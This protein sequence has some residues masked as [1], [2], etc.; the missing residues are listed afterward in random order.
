MAQL[1]NHPFFLSCR[2]Y[3]QFLEQ[4]TGI[5][6]ETTDIKVLADGYCS[7]IDH[8]DDNNKNRYFSA[9]M[10]RFW[11]QISKIQNRNYGINLDYDEFLSWVQEGINYAMK[12]RVWQNPDKHCNAQQA[13]NQCINTIC[14][15][16]Y[17]NLNSVKDKANH[18]TISLDKTIDT[19]GK[20]TVGDL[21][22]DSAATNYIE[23]EIADDS[24]YHIIK[25]YLAKNKI[26]EG[27]ILNT[28]AYEDCSRQ[29]KETDKATNETDEN[30]S[31][32]KV[33]TE[34]YARKCVSIL[35]NLPKDFVKA[36]STYYNVDKNKIEAAYIALTK[37][38]STKI[39]RWLKRTLEDAKKQ[40]E[41]FNYVR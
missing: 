14:L 6:Y 40:P 28:I 20:V 10:L 38:S 26:I 16:H 23:N 8:D 17:Y 19:D 13:I 24:T 32:P 11:Y 3:A 9:L 35:A 27:I 15:Q 18:Y 2:K 30:Y 4:E 33:K 34:F 5:N 1:N 12:Y 29:V 31:V 37:A 21:L 22:V 41:L 36:F 25:T 39:N 7:A